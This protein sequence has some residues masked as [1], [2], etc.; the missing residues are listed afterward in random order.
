MNIVK[1]DSMYSIV[2]HKGSIIL[3]ASSTEQLYTQALEILQAFTQPVQEN[4]ISMSDT[5][6]AMDILTNKYNG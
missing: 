1:Q 4:V 2:D 6:K 3:S 5:Q